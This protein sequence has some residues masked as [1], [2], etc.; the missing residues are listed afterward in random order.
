MRKNRKKKRKEMGKKGKKEKKWE[1]RGK[2]EKMGKKRKNGGKKK[3]ENEDCD[4]LQAVM[5]TDGSRE[6]SMGSDRVR[7]PPYPHF[8]GGGGRH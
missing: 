3:A 4:A 8:G 7:F 2:K 6:Q 1:K 5:G